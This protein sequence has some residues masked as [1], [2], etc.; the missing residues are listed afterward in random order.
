MV[1]FGQSLHF[2]KK[3]LDVLGSEKVIFVP[4]EGAKHSG[5]AFESMENLEKV[6]SFLN[7]LLK[8]RHE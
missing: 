4:L 3:L 5:K 1:P 6:F 2:Y 8:A 7:R